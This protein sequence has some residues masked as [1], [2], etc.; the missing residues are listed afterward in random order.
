MLCI[1][2]GAVRIVIFSASGREVRFD[3]LAAGDCF[4]ELACLDGDPR[5]AS[6]VALGDTVLA[7]NAPALLEKV[8]LEEPA[9][10][11]TMM[12]RMARLVRNATDRIVDLSVLGAYNRVCAELLR[13]ASHDTAGAA[14]AVVRPYPLRIDIAARVSTS[15]GTVS[16]V[17][18][19]LTRAKL[20]AKE[21]DGL[22]VRDLPRLKRMVERFSDDPEEHATLL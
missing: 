2:R 11:R 7:A 1:V 16:R 13:L 3:D 5:S 14:T 19:D 6:A 20:V 12:R 21:R 9:V 10:A 4:G 8:L 18:N 15:E 22:V 17:L